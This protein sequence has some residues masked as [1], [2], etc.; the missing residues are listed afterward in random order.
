MVTRA[1]QITLMSLLLALPWWSSTVMTLFPL[2]SNDGLT[3]CPFHAPS[4]TCDAASVL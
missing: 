1:A 2:T 4:S 3:D